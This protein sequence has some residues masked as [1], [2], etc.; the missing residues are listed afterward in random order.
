[1]KNHRP[2]DF[3]AA[4]LLALSLTANPGVASTSRPLSLDEMVQQSAAIVVG[5]VGASRTRWGDTSRR[6][7]LT[8]FTLA[9]DTVLYDGEQRVPIDRRIL[10]NYWG[11]TLD[12]ET[13]GIAGLKMP[14]TGE[15]LLL[16]LRPR[17]DTNGFSPTVAIDQGT[18]T[19]TLA[20]AAG[21]TMLTDSY[22]RTIVSNA[23]GNAAIGGKG[24]RM[25][26][27]EFAIWLRANGDRIRQTPAR[28]SPPRTQDARVLPTFAKTP[29][30]S[31][32]RKPVADN[33][34]MPVASALSGPAGSGF[35]HPIEATFG[36]TLSV[37]SLA[38]ALR[39]PVIG[40][41]Y[42]TVHQAHPPIV[43]NVFPSSFT[44]WSPEDQYQLGK[45]NYYAAD[46]FRRYTVATGTYGWPDNR[47]D[48][49]GWPSSAD[50]Q[51]V[52]GRGWGANE[53]GVTFYRWDGGG[54]LLEA[55]ISLNPAVSW[56][57]D[58]EWVYDGSFA[59]SF[60]N[61]MLH[62]AG[63]MHGL[64]HSF[65]S[66]SL[67]NYMPDD[68]RGF[69]FP[70]ADDA[71]GVRVE[72]PSNV[73]AVNDL[74][75]YL[76]VACGNQ[77]V[78]D[79]NYPYSVYAG[80]KLSLQ[81]YHVEN[82]GTTTISTPTI[83]WYLTEQRNFVNNYYG[84]GSSTYSSL[85][86]FTYFTPSSVGINL[87]VPTFVRAG[88]YYLA[89][90]IRGDGGAAGSTFGFSN[91]FAFSRLT[92]VVV[93]KTY[94]ALTS[95][96]EPSPSGT[97]LTLIAN[98]QGSFGSNPSGFVSF[99]IDGV[100]VSGCGTAP[101][102][103]VSFDAAQATCV[104]SS[105]TLGVHA[106]TA[107]YGGSVNHQAS[108][109]SMFQ[110]IA[111]VA[112]TACAGFTDVDATHALCASVEWLKNRN[113][114]LGCGGS[115]YCPAQPVLRLSM[116]AFMDRLADTPISGHTFTEANAGSHFA[117]LFPFGAPVICTTAN[118]GANNYPRTA[119]IESVLVA[120]AGGIGGSSFHELVYSID[121]GT[122]WNSLGMPLP[123]S[124]ANGHWTNTR[125]S[126]SV[127]VAAN[128][129][130]QFGIRLSGLSQYQMTLDDTRCRIGVRFTSGSSNY[131]PFDPLRVQ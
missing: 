83:E 12:G 7:M 37:N 36:P 18:F 118:L 32:V 127:N 34:S 58:D 51:R 19:V 93:G 128:Q 90:F 130:V 63:H 13:Q 8:E 67:M 112:G 48:L 116:A 106:V 3:A 89:G 91:N 50:L 64:E 77:C 129:S 24:T 102:T 4:L 10:L 17:D 62:E 86:P 75:A 74:A 54:W 55:D 81:N 100:P 80:N 1:M 46:L 125:N 29:D 126:A 35:P 61:T 33:S 27:A 45:W 98:L 107:T 65:N 57:L 23:A 95:S 41:S 76:Y 47:F 52:Y 122:S 113:V 124:V 104:I 42:S 6:W 119:L 26:V 38:T 105:M 56:T 78:T 131:S 21:A 123:Y 117:P 14:R 39:A 79:A 103:S 60:R 82:V 59:Y 5:T 25:T 111:P 99:Q 49:T 40:P 87:D 114:T 101:V 11:G 121:G 9:V 15:R 84:L 109:T 120:N 16:M 108:S 28:S 94:L 69:A 70:Y 96:A 2:C 110:T 88:K 44:L 68:F 53:L 20:D 72:Y 71:Q 31:G 115:L 66:L 30:F 92:L 22:G 97:P 85:P 43:V 73:A